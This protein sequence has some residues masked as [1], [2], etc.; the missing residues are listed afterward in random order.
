MFGFFKRKKGIEHLSESEYVE[1][2]ENQVWN[3]LSDKGVAYG[4]T[5]VRIM[6]NKL[7]LMLQSPRA[8]SLLLLEGLRIPKDDEGELLNDIMWIEIVEN[9]KGML[10][11]E[12]H[13]D[14]NIDFLD[15]Y[16]GRKLSLPEK[17]DYLRKDYAYFKNIDYKTAKE[18][19][20]DIDLYGHG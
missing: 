19:Q 20:E 6:N 10:N 12:Q 1:L 3:L 17:M 13:I 16:F 2:L 14:E 18:R 5:Q 8:G 4:E 15:G 9:I 7:E 11:L